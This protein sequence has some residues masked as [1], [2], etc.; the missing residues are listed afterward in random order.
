MEGN[1]YQLYDQFQQD[2]QQYKDCYDFNI[3]NKAL[4]QLHKDIK[5]I[6][7]RT[8]FYTQY[9]MQQIILNDTYKEVIYEITLIAPTSP[10]QTSTTNSISTTIGRINLLSIT[11]Y[12]EMIR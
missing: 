1:D 7:D 9:Y 11:H 5:V 10:T 6:Q 8:A 3:R 12:K 2:L 4:L